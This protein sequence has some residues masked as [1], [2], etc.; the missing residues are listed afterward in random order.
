[1]ADIEIRPT[2]F[3]D[4]EMLAANLRESDRAELEAVGFDD[5]LPAITGS[6]AV[7][8]L[9]WTVTLGGELVCIMGVSPFEGNT[10]SPWMLGTSLLA[11]CSRVLVR[12][13][14]DYIERML[15]VFPHLLNFV[16]AKNSTSVRWLRRLGFTLTEP[17]P[18][19]TRGELF[20]QFE[21]HA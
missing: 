14:P 11:R 1:M 21:M 17:Q 4:A 6:V 19:G 10:G 12:V 13:T 3:G 18:Y 9:C 15:V 20:H 16:H 8:S 5:P 2:R 7:S